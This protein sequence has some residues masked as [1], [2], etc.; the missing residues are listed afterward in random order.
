MYDS[1]SLNYAFK[2]IT[3]TL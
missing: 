1:E 3:M 2:N